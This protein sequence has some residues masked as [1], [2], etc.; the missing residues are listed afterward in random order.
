M[1]GEGGISRK[2]KRGQSEEW[3]RAQ[4]KTN[5]MQQRFEYTKRKKG[6]KFH[7]STELRASTD[8][9]AII[10]VPVGVCASDDARKD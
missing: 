8:L 9:Q 4:N 1:V 10:S 7:K 5:E 6:Q 3:T 2:G